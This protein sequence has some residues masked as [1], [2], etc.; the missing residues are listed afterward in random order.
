MSPYHNRKLRPNAPAHFS[1]RHWLAASGAAL[2]L[3]AMGCSH[4]GSR[5]SSPVFLASGQR[6]DQH[7]EQTIHDGLLAVGF[8]LKNLQDRR[9]L[10]KPNF[11]EPL[12]SAPQITT[13]PAV[14]AAAAEV[15]RR[16]GATVTVGEGP[17]H[18]R[19]TD[20]I[21]DEARVSSMLDDCRLPY[22]DLNYDDMAPVANRGR[23]SRLTEFYFPRAVL[24]ADL[25]VS[26]PKLKTHHWVG[27]TAALKNMYGTL[28]G[29][30]YGWPKNVLHH[31]GI[32]YTV[33]DINA[34]LPPTIAIVDGILCME[35]DGPILGT[36]KPLGLI[37]I[38]TNSTALDATLA[39][40]IGLAPERVTYLHLANGLL[41]PIDDFRI[42]Q[43]GESWQSIATPFDMLETPH[44]SPL[45]A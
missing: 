23:T 41:G 4:R 32:P 19:D 13:H 27:L 9:V 21:L 31:A 11:V 44:L 40:I 16:H 38:S 45:R 43:R 28:P 12:L 2:G 17:G 37:A 6:Y 7:L 34:S 39:R 1:R 8:S 15:F 29:L 14:I 36:A 24:E 30:K 35:G 18:M 26:M 22:V 20:F 10:L 42:K 33:V 25:V 3:W 5:S